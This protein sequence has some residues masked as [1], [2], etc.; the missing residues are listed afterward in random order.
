M[1]IEV[2][3][4][5][6]LVKLHFADSSTM[7]PGIPSHH[8]LPPT[9]HPRHSLT[10]RYTHT[11]FWT[12]Q[13]RIPRLGWDFCIAFV[14]I[15]ASHS[16]QSATVYLLLSLMTFSTAAFDIFFWSPVYAV[17][18]AASSDPMQL[19]VSVQSLTVGLFY[20][21]TAIVSWGSFTTVREAQKIRREVEA[22]ARWNAQDRAFRQIAREA[23]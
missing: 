4:V 13:L 10:E 22:H 6:V 7:S 8:I 9:L 15:V 1:S 20:L 2:V 19:L 18:G 5:V 16:K 12:I 3:L 17:I 23:N 11:N 21:L 14:A